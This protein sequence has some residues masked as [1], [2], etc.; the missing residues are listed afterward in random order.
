MA[1]NSTDKTGSETSTTDPGSA[2]PYLT[3]DPT[4]ARNVKSWAAP[5]LLLPP[6]DVNGA[7]RLLPKHQPYFTK[8]LNMLEVK[9]LKSKPDSS[10]SFLIYRKDSA[11]SKKVAVGGKLRHVTGNLA[12]Y[13]EAFRTRPLNQPELD[14]KA[15]VLFDLMLKGKDLSPYLTHNRPGTDVYIDLP[16]ENTRWDSAGRAWTVR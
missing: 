8:R 5:Y 6:K 7:E 12:Q 3:P 16:A 14:Q 13:I 2:W 1:C 4:L 9:A 10:I 15:L 11:G